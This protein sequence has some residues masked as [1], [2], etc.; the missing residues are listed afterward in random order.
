MLVYL[1]TFFISLLFLYLGIRD[2]SC[3]NNKLFIILA[4]MF[5]CFLA[6][7]RDISIG[8][9]TKGYVYN[10]FIF[11]KD[12]N[13]LGNF[14]KTAYAWYLQ[15]DYLYLTNTFL[16]AKLGLSLKVLFFTNEFLVIVPIYFAFR[17]LKFNRN[18]V[19]I[20]MFTFFFVFYNV[21]YNM[22]R[23][24][25]AIAFAVLAFSIYSTSRNKKEKILSYLVLLIAIGFHT[26]S[27]LTILLFWLYKFYNSKKIS[28]NIKFGLFY[29]GIFISILI[30]I[31]YEPFLKF[32]ANTGIY[33]LA[34]LYMERYSTKDFSF[35]QLTINLLMLFMIILNK[36]HIVKKR[37]NYYFLLLI[38]IINLIISSGLGYFIMYSQ[39]VVYYIQY[40]LLLCYIPNIKID[41]KN[42]KNT[43]LIYL[44]LLMI[45]WFLYFVIKDVHETVPYIANF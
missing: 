44:F 1:C 21:T 36:D 43:Y 32:L 11:A 17:R 41:N 22:V 2:K 23:Q 14:F 45:L 16:I 39:R 19:L 35:Y 31:L 15:K 33:S 9:D 34:D 40:I 27:I 37:C 42:Q 3:K 20:A 30:V 28:E 13:G 25:I 38:S 26:T 12:S 5:P 29:C 24:S 18:S 4:L 10:L 8:S 7:F 6:A